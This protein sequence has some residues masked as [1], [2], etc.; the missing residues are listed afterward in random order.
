[1]TH[2]TAHKHDPPRT[3][4]A[5]YQ[6]V[7]DAPAH[8]VAEIVDPF[9][10]ECRLCRIP[11]QLRHSHVIPRLMFRPM[12]RLAPGTPMRVASSEGRSRPGHLKEY[13]LCA[14]CEEQFSAH[15]RIAARFLADL[16]EH[17]LHARERKIRR[18][19]LDYANLKLFF[20]SV[21]WRC[22]VARDPMTRQVNLG[23][24]LP[25][26]TALLQASDPGGQEEFAVL[27]RL[28]DESPIA[29]NAVL[30]VPVPMREGSRRGYAMVGNGVEISWVADQR[31]APCG[32]AP[33]ILH[34]D[35]TWLI[36]VISGS[37]SFPWRQSVTRSHEQDRRRANER[38][39]R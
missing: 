21:L 33:W 4:R 9:F 23:R 25:R 5:T 2:C 26:L 27:L 16:N 14:R 18:S 29:R 34:E 24:R 17:Q 12:A 28:L 35:G 15:E 37:R 11:A 19:Y 1:M 39:L 22:A 6:D 8:R 30:T 20:L 31:G 38:A 13:M 7:L 10:R 32:S 3:P 36:E